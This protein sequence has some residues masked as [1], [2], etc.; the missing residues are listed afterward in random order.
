MDAGQLDRRVTIQKR[1]I[2]QSELG[3]NVV[4][5]ETVATV[6]AKLLSRKGREFYSGGAVIGADDTTW[7]FR[8]QESIKDID[9][10]WRLIV[11][12]EYYD[13]TSIDDT[14]G[15]KYL[16]TVNAKRGSNDG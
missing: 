2:T 3:D 11:N 9:Q 15:R 4:T 13:I 6:W 10:T 1:L 16:L 12:D 5:F 8:Y 14:N 7:Q